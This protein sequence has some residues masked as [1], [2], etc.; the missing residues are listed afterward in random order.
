MGSTIIN[1]VVG[2]ETNIAIE[3]LLIAPENT[4][5]DGLR[6]D[7]DAPPAGFQSLGAV[8]EEA[9]VISVTREKLE[10]R[11][12]I[13][14]VLQ[15]NAVTGLEGK[16]SSVLL[17]NSN[18]KAVF[19]MGASDVLNVSPNAIISLVSTAAN[20]LTASVI[21]FSAAPTADGKLVVGDE[22]IAST[23]LGNWEVSSNVATVAS[24]DATNPTTVFHLFPVFATV[25][26]EAEFAARPISSR[27][28]LGTSVLKKYHLLGVADWLDGS[29]L[30]HTFP[31]VSAF[32]EWTEEIRPSQ[33]GR[34]PVSFD[35]FGVTT[36]SFN[37]G[38]SEL[39][40]GERVMIQPV[41]P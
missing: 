5:W 29:Q 6:I 2:R 26:L 27:L 7:V 23:T 38:T 13:P 31:K 39:I 22:V 18:R 20:A 32:G 9:S 15:F 3:Q 14:R 40:V 12:G 35:A 34:I 8:D 28:A 16:I 17:S 21:T 4:V 33:T 1:K 10:L 11:T 19:A 41:N 37:S 24:L 30:V 36:T 25:P